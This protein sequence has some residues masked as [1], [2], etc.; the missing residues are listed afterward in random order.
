MQSTTDNVIFL[1]LSQAALFV[2]LIIIVYLVILKRNSYASR[3][4]R[5]S[6]T[7]IEQNLVMEAISACVN[8]HD[9]GKTVAAIGRHA[10]EVTGYS[11]WLL[12]VLDDQSRSLRLYAADRSVSDKLKEKLSLSDDPLLY[13]WVKRNE[14]PVPAGAFLADFVTDPDLAKILKVCDRGLMIPLFDGST[15]QGFII[16]YQNKNLKEKRSRQFLSLFGAISAVILKKS[17]MDQKQNLIR[18]KQMKTENLASLGQLAAGMA[19]EIRTPLTLIKSATQHL[20]NYYDYEPQDQELAGV[21]TEEINRINQ[22]IQD[23][24]ILGRIAPAESGEVELKGLLQKSIKLCQ[25]KANEHKVTLSAALPDRSVAVIGNEE[26]LGQL[27]RNLILNAIDAMEGGGEVNISSS[28]L[29]QSVLTV[30]SDTGPGIAPEVKEKIFEPFFTTKSIGTG[31]GLSVSYNIAMAHKG[32]LE[33]IKSDSS[34]SSFQ[35]TL[36]LEENG[37]GKEDV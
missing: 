23:L 24:L 29:D 20:N 27:F 15:T 37:E 22:Q 25:S 14:E 32:E 31:L 8:E 3:G 11:H 9:F 36:P 21:I 19:H 2:V 4:V 33:L 18:K 12:W 28:F 13:D 6:K 17:R 16:L 26:L 1:A 10:A 35:V 5:K 7:L 30:I 34:G